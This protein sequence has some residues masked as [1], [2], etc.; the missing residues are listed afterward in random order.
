MPQNLSAWEAQLAKSL[1]APLRYVMQVLC[2]ATFATVIAYF[3]TAPAYRLLTDGDAVV[4]LS[5]S[6]SAQLKQ[7]CRERNE[8]E[9]AKLAPNMRNKFDCPRERVAVTVELEMD[10]ALL[11]RIDTPPSGLS[12][13]GAA[14]VYRRF[15]VPAGRHH[16]RARLADGPDGKFN[17]HHA[18]NVDLA[19]GQ[20]LIIDFLSG[21]G[22]FVFLHGK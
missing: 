8:A 17:H 3:S 22:G 11:Y 12:R 13:D 6:H 15:V 4:K 10:D 19:P 5:F 7:I 14:T 21:S 1:P 9:L 16:F 18:A 2:Y 20:V